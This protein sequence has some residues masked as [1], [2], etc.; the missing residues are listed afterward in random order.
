MIRMNRQIWAMTTNANTQN[1]H[2][3]TDH[4][5]AVIYNALHK[6]SIVIQYLK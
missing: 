1:R 4:S 2:A 3:K 5:F 6:I